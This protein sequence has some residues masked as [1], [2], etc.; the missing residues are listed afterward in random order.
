MALFNQHCAVYLAGPQ[1][2]AG[3]VDGGQGESLVEDVV[4]QQHYAPFQRTLRFR[5]PMQFTPGGVGAVAGCV[6]I[7]ELQWEGQ[8][9]DELARGHQAALHDTQH[10]GLLVAQRC[11]NFMRQAVQGRLHLGFRI[12][13]VRLFVYRQGL[14][15]GRHSALF[16]PCVHVIGESRPQLVALY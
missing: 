12:Q 14:C 1:G 6:D 7:V 2:Q 11:G 9:I 16:C 5:H 15:E 4:H 10:H 3:L 13:D 8:P